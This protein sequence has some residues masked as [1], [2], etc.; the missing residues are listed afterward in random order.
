ML[1]EWLLTGC[2]VWIPLRTAE[3]QV[4][5]RDARLPA[6]TFTALGGVRSPHRS[7]FHSH[8]FF[9]LYSS[10]CI[11]SYNHHFNFLYFSGSGF[12]FHVWS[13]LGSLFPRSVLYVQR[14]RRTLGTGL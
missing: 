11:L 10:H 1:C 13:S 14:G 8:R 9:W 3:W 7:M 12:E 5:N 6:G 4:M 2:L